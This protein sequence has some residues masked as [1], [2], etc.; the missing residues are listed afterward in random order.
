[1]PVTAYRIDT[2]VRNVNLEF[3]TDTPS[4]IKS[5]SEMYKQTLVPRGMKVINSTQALAEIYMNARFSAGLD[6]HHR[7]T[8]TLQQQ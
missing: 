2:F 6:T 3:V 4:G 5:M 8:T 7:T 1:M